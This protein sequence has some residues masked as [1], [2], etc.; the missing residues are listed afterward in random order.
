MSYRK[1]RLRH[2]KP[3]RCEIPDCTRKGG[4]S[5]RNDLDRH[6]KSLHK[7]V[8]KTSTDKTYKCAAEACARVTKVW[9]RADN[10]RQ[11]CSRKHKDLHLETLVQDSLV[12]SLWL[13]QNGLMKGE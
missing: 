9:P 5:T 4:F 2:E 12:D 11:H 7:I 8:P 6:R 3:F 1:H 13:I 10:F